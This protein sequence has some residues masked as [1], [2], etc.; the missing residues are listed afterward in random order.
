MTMKNE[1][2]VLKT[3]FVYKDVYIRFKH[4]ALFLFCGFKKFH[5]LITVWFQFDLY[6]CL[7]IFL[8]KLAYFE[9]LT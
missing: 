2:H 8:L 1:Q 6:L 5:I 9:L 3:H 4:N 7:Y